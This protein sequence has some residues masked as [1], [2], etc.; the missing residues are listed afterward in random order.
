MDVRHIHS[1]Q[2]DEAM[3]GHDMGVLVMLGCCLGAIVLGIF[4]G[5]I[6]I[7]LHFAYGGLVTNYLIAGGF[8]L[9]LLGLGACKYVFYLDKKHWQENKR[10]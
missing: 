4:L 9:T 5:G 2:E 1:K 7:I 3:S 8:G 10:K 6:G